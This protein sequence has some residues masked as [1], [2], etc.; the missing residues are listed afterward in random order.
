[1]CGGAA[2]GAHDGVERFV[3][4]FF[5]LV[6]PLLS[7]SRASL[8]ES[9]NFKRGKDG[10][11]RRRRRTGEEKEGKKEND[12]QLHAFLSFSH[13][14][15]ASFLR[16]RLLL[17]VINDI[18]CRVSR[19]IVCVTIRIRRTLCIEASGRRYPA[20][21]HACRVN[22]MV[23][24]PASTLDGLTWTVPGFSWQNLLGEV[25]DGG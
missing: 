23:T 25:V 1:M 13:A 15:F 9:L 4:P 22:L 21:K 24:V 11:R 20:E 12:Q 19:E 17:R 2:V 6:L 18:I 5:L 3:L 7:S 14:R 16:L 10:R 8:F